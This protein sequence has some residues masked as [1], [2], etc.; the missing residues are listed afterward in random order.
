MNYRVHRSGELYHHGVGGMKWG[1]RRYQN[2][3]GS[4]TPEGR[5]HYGYNSETRRYTKELNRIDR[6][7]IDDKRKLH[8][9]QEEEKRYRSKLDRVI[10]KN[11]KNGVLNINKKTGD[12]LHQYQ[13]KI[14]S[15]INNSEFYR[16]RIEEA[17]QKADRIISEAESKGY[18]VDSKDV[19]RLSITGGDI[20]DSILATAAVGMASSIAGLP[21]TAIIVSG[22]PIQGKK[23]KVK[24]I[25]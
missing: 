6:S 5:V 24:T 22:Q 14:N 17:K 11:T 10:K 25:K 20:C 2:E 21:I 8:D 19:T 16:K 4:L 3:D 13:S 18:V 12:K 23:Y 7:T 15:E 1:V 9:S